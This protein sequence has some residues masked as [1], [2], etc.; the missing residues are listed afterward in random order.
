MGDSTTLPDSSKPNKSDE[1]Q[2]N[3][4]PPFGALSQT[5]GML[6]SNDKQRSSQ[7]LRRSRD[8][9]FFSEEP[10]KF[11]D[12]EERRRAQEGAMQEQ[13]LALPRIGAVLAVPQ[14]Q[15]ERPALGSMTQAHFR[16]ESFGRIIKKY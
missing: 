16:Q 14:L 7:Y 13:E 6:R 11:P 12:I 15:K 5:N 10:V 9:H 2:Q 3:T 4:M 8:Q 1:I